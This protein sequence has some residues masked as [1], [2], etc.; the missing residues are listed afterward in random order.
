MSSVLFSFDWYLLMRPH[1]KPNICIALADLSTAGNALLH[2][3][4]L[5]FEII[6]PFERILQVKIA[7]EHKRIWEK[8]QNRGC[9]GQKGSFGDAV[10]YITELSQLPSLVWA[11][12]AD[13]AALQMH[14]HS[15]I[16]FHR[17]LC[18]LNPDAAAPATPPP[19][20]PA[21][22]IPAKKTAIEGGHHVDIEQHI[23]RRRKLH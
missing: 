8:R 2:Q 3:Y 11:P 12:A 17:Q 5:L 21:A 10:A 13:A 14:K 18:T 6:I 19:W 16:L 23:V 7:S 20:D 9:L 15:L 4:K 1:P 22:S